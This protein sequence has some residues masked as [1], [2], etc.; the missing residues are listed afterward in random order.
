[1]MDAR[2]K[3]YKALLNDC[4]VNGTSSLMMRHLVR[5]MMN[6]ACCILYM[7]EQLMNAIVPE[8]FDVIGNR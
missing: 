5:M 6:E 7:L 3:K 4:M 8:F 2:E 1:M